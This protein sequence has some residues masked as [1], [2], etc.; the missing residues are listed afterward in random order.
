MSRVMV[1]H[2]CEPCAASRQSDWT[3]PCEMCTATTM[4]SV[5]NA[6]LVSVNRR[7][8]PGCPLQNEIEEHR[9]LGDEA[10]RR[11]AFEVGLF[12]IFF[13]LYGPTAIF[14]TASSIPV[15]LPS[16]PSLTM[17]IYTFTR[18][19]LTLIRPPTSQ[20][21]GHCPWYHLQPCRL[22]RRDG[23]PLR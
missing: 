5:E 15:W 18:S 22:P 11:D 16:S 23:T 1:W 12:N 4:N 9:C 21:I 8:Q 3:H 14:V 17:N 6:V 10:E 13:F 2:R 7:H 20:A 19:T